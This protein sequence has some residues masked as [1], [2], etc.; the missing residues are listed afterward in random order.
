[1]RDNTKSGDPPLCSPKSICY[2]AGKVPDPSFKDVFLRND[3]H[4]LGMEY[5]EDIALEDVAT[6]TST[7]NIVRETFSKSTAR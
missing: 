2:L 4:Q 7:A 6:K 1:M 5:L 3:V